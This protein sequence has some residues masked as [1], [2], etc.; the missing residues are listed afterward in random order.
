MFEIFWSS[1]Y[2]IIVFVSRSLPR[3]FVVKSAEIISFFYYLLA[4]RSRIIVRDNLQKILGRDFREKYVI[5]TFKNFSFYLVDFIRINDDM[6]KFFKKYV[7]GE[8]ISII[9]TALKKSHGG[10]VG[11]SIHM[12]TGKL[13][14]DTS[15]LWDIVSLQ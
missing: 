7:Q 5:N 14:E 2:R 10:T 6:R 8:N 11:L 4:K 9:N 13:G 1:I 15:H 3:C 12:G